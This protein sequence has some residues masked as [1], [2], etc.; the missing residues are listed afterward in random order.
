MLVPAA[1]R[2]STALR[3]LPLDMPAVL[4]RRTAVLPES[5][6]QLGRP[7]RTTTARALADAAGWARS[8][9]EARSILAAGCQQRRTTAGE[10][11]AVAAELPKLCRRP[12]ILRTLDDVEGGAQ[13]LSELDFVALCR[14][15]RLPAPDLQQH[16][17]DTSGRRRYLDA[18]WRRWRLH[19]E[20][21]GA[22]HMDVRH[23]A[24]DLR[25]QNE[26]WIAGDRILRFPAFLVR[27]RPAEVAG[28]VRAGLEAA[29][30]RA[31]A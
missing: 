21:D 28:Q 30:W 25:R 9:D 10:I 6:L 12:L 20:V 17:V 7:T 11:R 5:H 14:R 19:V 4:V 16:R 13:A 3:R 31:D 15:F 22:H 2:A 29:G 18:Y 1:R 26:I 23:W 8:D 24:A 27:S